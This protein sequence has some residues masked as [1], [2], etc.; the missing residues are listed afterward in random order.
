MQI[1]SLF[2]ALSTITMGL[3]KAKTA[4]KTVEMISS[5]A[6]G[7]TAA[8]AVSAAGGFA[9]GARGMAGFKNILGNVGNIFKT[10]IPIL[11][12]IP[13]LFL[14]LIPVVGAVFAVFSIGLA[15]FNKT[16]DSI[17][18][19]GE[20][21][22]LSADKLKKVGEIFGTDLKTA[23]FGSAFTGAAAKGTSEQ[24]SKTQ[25]VLETETFEADFK[26]Q[27]DA[28]KNAGKQDAERTLNALALQL[29]SAGLDSEAVQALIDAIVIKAERTD[30]DLK[31][32][33]VSFSSAEGLASI[34][35][36]ADDT[37]KLLS[38]KFA[39]MGSD[40][41]QQFLNLFG[42]GDFQTQIETSAGELSSILQSL[43]IGFENLET[44]KK[45]CDPLDQ[46]SQN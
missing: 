36:I 20:T 32:A 44:L 28:I 21:A 34:T 7:R 40:F 25:Q 37:S 41:G 31:F 19:L 4:Q 35:K 24:R 17:N 10:F 23:D 2:F 15:V 33:G 38:A 3:V 30:L 29:S 18:R 22:N 16:K 12:K 9:G 43:K 5:L 27:I 45:P 1:T 11:G 46:V 26:T 42:G 39:T 8:G 6:S 14:K 13:S